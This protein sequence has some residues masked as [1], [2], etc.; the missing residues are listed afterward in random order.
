MNQSSLTGSR[1]MPARNFDVVTLDILTVYAEDEGVYK[2]VARS[3]FGEAVAS[4]TLKCKGKTARPNVRP[5]VIPALHHILRDPQQAQSWLRIQQFESRQRPEPLSMEPEK[6]PPQ[7]T[8][9]LA[10]G[11]A[12]VA[13]GAPVHLECQVQPITDPHLRIEWYHNDRP[14]VNA[15]R[16]RLTHDFGYV[17]LD[18][19][20]VFPEDTGEWKA[21]ATNDLGVAQTVT[22]LKVRS[23]VVCRPSDYT[24]PI[25]DTTAADDCHRQSQSVIS[26]FD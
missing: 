23:C 26:G 10:D 22:R 5:H 6:R 2:C 7:F 25:A 1:F 4:C 12:T 17:A 16:L 21:V 15:H 14:I 24:T 18:L 11:I 13:E 8:R 9:P 3:A 19:L 20:Y